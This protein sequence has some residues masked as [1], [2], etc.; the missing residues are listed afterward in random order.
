MRLVHVLVYL[1]Q[2]NLDIRHYPG[3]LNIIPDALSRLNIIETKNISTNN[4]LEYIFLVLEVIIKLQLKARIWL[5]LQKDLKFAR[6]LK[7]LEAKS[8]NNILE[9]LYK[10]KAPFQIKNRLLFYII[11]DRFRLYIP[12]TLVKDILSIAYNKFYFRNKYTFYKL[13]DFYILYL[14]KYI[15]EYIAY[16]LVYQLNKTSRH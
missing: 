2:F 14:I 7:V 9:E 13:D 10:N 4:E 11:R 8:S 15:E 3:H 1:S 5:E 16:Y 12:K 6:V